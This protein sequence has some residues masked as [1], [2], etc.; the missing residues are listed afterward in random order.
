[1]IYSNKVYMAMSSGVCQAQTQIQEQCVLS[2]NQK[3]GALGV[4]TQC[5]LS[6]GLERKG[7]IRLRY[8]HQVYSD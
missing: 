8:K 2:S 5:V 7:V 4:Q 1:M 6:L 3:C